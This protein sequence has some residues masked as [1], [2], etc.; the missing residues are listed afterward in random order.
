MEIVGDDLSIEVDIIDVGILAVDV[1]ED[2]G[3]LLAVQR[4]L[5]T[6]SIIITISEQP[7]IGCIV[8]ARAFL[9][10]SRLMVN[11]QYHFLFF[12]GKV[13]FIIF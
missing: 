10:G 2:F 11:Q 9:D 5:D 8:K 3:I 6:H 13:L 1:P 7:I 4:K 12:L